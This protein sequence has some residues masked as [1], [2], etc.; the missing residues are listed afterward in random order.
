M[1]RLDDAVRIV[2]EDDGVGFAEQA[3]SD[4][5]FGRTLVDMLVRQLKANIEFRDARPGTRAVI[6]LPLNAEEAQL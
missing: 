1:S 2:V 3:S 6:V 5:S 4:E